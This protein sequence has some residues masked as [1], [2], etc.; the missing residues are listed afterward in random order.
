[1][2]KTY[3]LIKEYPGS[4]KL[5]TTAT[6]EELDLN[7]SLYLFHYVL[8]DPNH[9]PLP[10]NKVEDYPEF[11]EEVCVECLQSKPTCTIIKKCGKF[12][13]E[14]NYLITAFRNTENEYLMFLNN[15]GG[16]GRL[17]WLLD[18]MLKDEMYEIYSVK[19]S[20]GEEFTIGDK[21]NASTLKNAT[22][23]SFKIIDKSMVVYCDIKTNFL[24]LEWCS[25]AIQSPIYTTT[26]GVEIFEGDKY[27]GLYLLNKDIT[28][29]QDPSARVVYSFNSQDAEVCNRYLTFTS[30]ENR[31]KY[32]KENAKK[33]IF[34]SADGKEIFEG[35]KFWIINAYSYEFRGINITYSGNDEYLKFSTK[36]AAQEYIDNNKPKYS[37]KNIEKAFENSSISEMFKFKGLLEEIKK[38][39]K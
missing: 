36:Q 34:I 12:K 27:N 28:L 30:E 23:K 32:I 39:G 7:D 21:I 38:L 35:D 2:K 16:Y 6:L 15:D 1:M 20:K 19:N 8:N 13:E 9:Q 37:L 31:D 5:N 4:P 24:D 11:W 25:I 3:K 10:E 18:S 14:P 17:R 26:D 33:P 29:P 22:I